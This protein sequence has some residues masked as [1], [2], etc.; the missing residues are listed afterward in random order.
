VNIARIL[1]SASR[2]HGFS[3]S[4]DRTLTSRESRWNV[5]TLVRGGYL[6]KR[7][8]VL[9][10]PENPHGNWPEMQAACRLV[11]RTYH[12]TEKGLEYWLRGGAS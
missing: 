9:D 1:D 4:L 2:P 3:L 7:I 8:R 5:R 11:L 6:A 10:L 12:L